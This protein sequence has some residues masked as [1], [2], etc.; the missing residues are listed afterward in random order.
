MENASK[1]LIIAG[2][3]LISIV[4]IGVGV[5]IIGNAQ[6]IFGQGSTQMS[7]M[8]IQAFNEPFMAFEGKQ[9]G[10][11]VRSLLQKLATH[12][13]TYSEDTTKQIGLSDKDSKLTM[14]N[15]SATK[16]KVNV[17]TSYVVSF[18]YDSN[19]GMINNI[20]IKSGSN[21]IK[22]ETGTTTT[23]PAG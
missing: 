2:A 22:V 16:S 8:E 20:T 11:N 19:S 1:A 15:L 7:Q 10:S 12:N 9:S 21:E 6:G 17:G 4:L 5:L 13:Q 14:A 18:G 3:I 23:P